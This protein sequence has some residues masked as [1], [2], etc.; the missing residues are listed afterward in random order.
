MVR[1]PAFVVAALYEDALVGEIVQGDKSNDKEQVKNVE[2]EITYANKSLGDNLKNILV[3]VNN[4]GIDHMPDG[5]LNFLKGILAACKLSLADVAIINLANLPP[6]SYKTLMASHKP[7][8]VLLFDVP[9]GDFGLPMNF[10]FYQIQPFAGS[11]FLYS[12][13]LNNLE[14]DKIEKSKL[15]VSLKRLFNL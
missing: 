12:P 1:L 6:S 5:D 15:W 3:L 11:S 13:S 9:P 8:I 7:K 10:P 2:K 4:P 14:N